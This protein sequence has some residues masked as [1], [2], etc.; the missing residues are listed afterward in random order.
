MSDVQPSVARQELQ[1]ST[2]F[3]NR[4]GVLPADLDLQVS[5]YE[6][7]GNGHT[8]KLHVE[9]DKIV[10]WKL[11]GETFS[12]HEL[13]QRSGGQEANLVNLKAALGLS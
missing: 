1:F 4:F 3:R 11:D 10:D 13:L 5:G 8:I 6:A 7:S 9:N 2:I 12:E